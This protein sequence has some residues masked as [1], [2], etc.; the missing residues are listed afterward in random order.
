MPLTYP[1]D[2]TGV[3]ATNLISNEEHTVSDQASRFFVPAGGPFFTK[4]MQVRKADNTLLQP[5]VDYVALHLYKDAVLATGKEVC[6][7]I[8]IKNPAIA[9]VVNVTYQVVGGDYSA[10]VDAL[11]QLLADNDLGGANTV[12]WGSIIGTPVQF[13]PSS[14]LHHSSNIFGM[15]ETVTVL[16]GIRNA[17][18]SG[19]GSIFQMMY[20]YIDTAIANASAGGGSVQDMQNIADGAVAAHKSELTAH[21]KA[22]VGL[23]VVQNF[24]VASGAEAAAGTAANRYMTPQR[25]RTTALQAISDTV[26][27]TWLGVD[28]LPNFPVASDAE[29]I[30]TTNDITLMTP[31]RVALMID[32]LRPA[33]AAIT[34]ATTLEGQ[35]GT[36][37]TKATTP[38]GARAAG[39]GLF[40]KLTTE[41]YTALSPNSASDTRPIFVCTHA[42]NPRPDMPYLIISYYDRTINVAITAAT[43]RVQL[44]MLVDNGTTPLVSTGF[45][46]AKRYFDGITWTAWT[47]VINATDVGLS[48]VQ[49]FAVGTSGESWSGAATAYATPASAV[50]AAKGVLR[51][52]GATNGNPDTT[53]NPVIVT[54]HANAPVAGHTFYIETVFEIA[55]ASFPND[56]TALRTQFARGKTI[57]GDYR[58]T[59]DGGSWSPWEQTNRFTG[60]VPGGVA[61]GPG[62]LGGITTGVL[63][64]AVGVDALAANTT[65]QYNTA[66]GC[67]A[68]SNNVGG[69]SNTAIGRQSLY[70]N[71]NGTLN[72]AIGQAALVYNTTGQHNVA[73][74][75]NALAENIVGRYHTAV[76]NDCLKSAATSGANTALGY[77]A[78]FNVDSG[79]GNIIIGSVTNTG[80]YAPVFNVTT[81]D[82]QIVLGH[83]SI[84]NARVKVAWTVTSDARD[85]TAFADVP[86]GLDFVNQLKPVAYRFRLNRET[87]ETNG[88]L[89]YGFKAQDVLALE[90]DVPVIIDTS[91][92]DHLGLNDGNLTPIIVQAIQ[93]MHREFTAQIAALTAE[94][95]TLRE[96]KE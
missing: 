72:I 73:I 89:R 57:V 95:A 8:Y 32:A 56:P 50:S 42:S 39:M 65:G 11:E 86:H 94:I 49:N 7:V 27:R 35:T 28:N 19:D 96:G 18:L 3:A 68:L 6:A 59:F 13:P 64:T 78:G 5:G 91:S 82:N 9:G 34:L 16:E 29:S 79:S 67:T 80:V 66:L 48:N 47:N 93:E 20:Q 87:E 33:V 58:R 46:I 45:N 62:A 25:T 63:N 23:D 10:T 84:T 14:H 85:K 17:I 90:G 71:T 52:V 53:L 75:N 12:A 36:N 26:T 54:A 30:L 88:P 51:H 92:P 61:L 44:A 15:A 1:Y 60:V 81:E 24:A 21:T 83:T 38:A 41:A 70:S 4:G 40:S 2:P 77:Q 31:K 37:T 74:G 69:N 76:G 22:Q 55:V 43:P